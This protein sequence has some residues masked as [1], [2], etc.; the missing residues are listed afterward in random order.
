MQPCKPV[1]L[2]T[3][4]VSQFQYSQHVPQGG[5]YSS[6]VAGYFWSRFGPACN[7]TTRRPPPHFLWRR[8]AGYTFKSV[9]GVLQGDLQG[10]DWDPDLYHHF[11]G[12][13][14]L[15]V[16]MAGAPFADEFHD[17]HSGWNRL[18]FGSR[19]GDLR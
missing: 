5:W 3:G 9:A 2:S 6:W 4:G 12:A 7:A 10:V 14:L 11:L 8:C 16:Y 17:C 13:Q 19:A 15:I 18:P 1:L